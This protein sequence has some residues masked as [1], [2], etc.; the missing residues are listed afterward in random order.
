MKLERPLVPRDEWV[1][2]PPSYLYT[3][4]QAPA[5]AAVREAMAAAMSAQSRAAAGRAALMEIEDAARSTVARTLGRPAT[6]VAFLGDASTAWNLVANGLDWQPGD[7][8]VLNELE[9]ASVYLPFLRWRPRG[10]DVRFAPVGEQG[11]V[12]TDA[13]MAQVD[14]RTRAVAIS[15]VAYVNGAR[16]DIGALA[17]ALGPQGVP[18]FVDWSHSLGVLPVDT[19][20]VALGVSASYKWT[21]GPYGVGILHWNPDLLPDFTPGS[22]GWRSVADLFDPERFSR[23]ALDPTASR[24]RQGAA[25]FCGIAGVAAGLDRLAEFPASMVAEHALGLASEAR[26]QLVGLGH[27]SLTPAA[28]DAGSGNVSIVMPEGERVAQLLSELGVEVWGGDGR[29]RASFHVMNSL[30][31]VTALVDAVTTISPAGAGL[32]ARV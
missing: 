13:L 4:A 17:R 21:L 10:L 9:H 26:R 30:A 25:S 29:I 5:L 18:L 3:G 2:L 6:E 7:N 32:S 16:H 27:A 24:F 1:S 15:H 23:I 14:E 11:L 28:V 8:V 12:E 31:D 19:A 22:V 20:G